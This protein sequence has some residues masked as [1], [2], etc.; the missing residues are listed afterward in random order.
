MND[1]VHLASLE[2]SEIVAS[3]EKYIMLFLPPDA[4]A[5]GF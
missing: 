1:L 4:A 3:T 5:Y 2:T